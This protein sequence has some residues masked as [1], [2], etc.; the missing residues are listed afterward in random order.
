MEGLTGGATVLT[1]AANVTFA[2]LPAVLRSNW[3]TELNDSSGQ[4]SD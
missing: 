1:V 3:G 4:M 2:Q